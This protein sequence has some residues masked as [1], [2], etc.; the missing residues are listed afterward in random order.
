MKN[1]FLLILIVLSTFLISCSNNK[2]AT[3]EE[4]FIGI[5]KP[6]T[7]DTTTP[8]PTLTISDKTTHYSPYQSLGNLV[9]FPDKENNNI[10]SSIYKQDK[11]GY[12]EQ[13]NIKDIFNYSIESITIIDEI[14][15]FSNCSDSNALYS[16]DYQSNKI[17]K[18]NSNYV[19][20]LTSNLNSLYYINKNDKNKLY[21]YNTATNSSS[22][23]SADSV[24]SF[25]INGDYILYQN[26]S[27]KSKLYSI[28][29]D[30]SN[31]TKLT[32]NSVNSFTTYKNE[33]LYVNSDDNNSLYRL[34]PTTFN[35]TR[36]NLVH[37]E[38]LKSYDNKLFI[39]DNDKSNSL[40][41]LV[42]DFDKNTA[43]TSNITS[44]TTN[45]FYPS[46][47]G[48]YLEKSPDVNKTYILK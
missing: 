47:D 22:T 48:I 7:T 42:V 5:N 37:G 4:N 8:K 27:D 40:S 32:D 3:N 1:K 19:F 15:Y 20:N 26:L 33:I 45:N 44:G 35:I 25:V 39:I 30:G 18:V 12:I 13:S 14:I 43:S 38:N 21:S 34:N 17:S 6:Q 28:K 2:T 46:T 16:L 23:L 24:G 9:F 11:S 36:L 10:L 29:L 41:S 31:R